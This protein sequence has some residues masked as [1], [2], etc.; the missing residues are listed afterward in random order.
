MLSIYCSIVDATLLYQFNLSLTFVGIVTYQAVLTIL[1]SSQICC[2]CNLIYNF[3]YMRWMIM[4]VVISVMYF[5]AYARYVY[6]LRVFPFF[7]CLCGISILDRKQFVPVFWENVSLTSS[8]LNQVLP[9]NNF[10]FYRHGKILFCK[11]RINMCTAELVIWHH[12][13]Q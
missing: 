5:L 10:L 7:L 8:I 6:F 13:A 12:R 2:L 3:K 11:L 4:I 9:L 1:L